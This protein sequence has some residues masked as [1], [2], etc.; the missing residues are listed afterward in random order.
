LKKLTANRAYIDLKFV[1]EYTS[2][3]SLWPRFTIPC[4]PLLQYEHGGAE[5]AFA[6]FCM[7]VAQKL[8]TVLNLNPK[9][10]TVLLEEK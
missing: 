2:N 1:L 9:I 5:R 6:R 4:P 3:P 7:P 8:G 10:A